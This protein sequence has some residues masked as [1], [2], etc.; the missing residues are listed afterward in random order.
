MTNELLNIKD[1]R[2][3]SRQTRNPLHI[4]E[5][6]LDIALAVTEVDLN[7]IDLINIRITDANDN[8]QGYTR[9]LSSNP[10]TGRLTLL[11]KVRVRKQASY[12]D[13]HQYVMNN[14]LLHELRHVAQ[15]QQTPNFDALY[16]LENSLNGYKNNVFETDAKNYGRIADH[17]GTKTIKDMWPATPLGQ[18]VWAIR[19]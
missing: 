12:T 16:K 6:A 7:K 18:Q 19:L 10:L 5:E 9:V 15:R 13:A 3:D 17:T 8:K 1:K 2:K 11:I 4:N 14:T